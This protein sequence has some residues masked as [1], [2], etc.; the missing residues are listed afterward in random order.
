M[1]SDMRE[2]YST[3]GSPDNDNQDTV[4]SNEDDTN[5]PVDRSADHAH[6]TR[7]RRKVKPSKY[8][9]VPDEIFTCPTCNKQFEYESQYNQHCCFKI[10]EASESRGSDGDVE[11]DENEEPVSKAAR[12]ALVESY[13]A[14]EIE[15]AAIVSE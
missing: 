15:E 8:V 14:M 3:T 12:A 4:D 2:Y 7:S 11:A 6:G 13:T 10:S 1:L 5:P 9:H